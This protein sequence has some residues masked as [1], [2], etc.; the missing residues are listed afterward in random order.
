MRYSIFLIALSGVFLLACKKK[1]HE[2]EVPAPAF[3]QHGLLVL[4][5]GLFQLNNSTLCWVNTDDHSVNTTFFEDKTQRGLGDTG[6]D[7]ARYG[8]KIYIVVNVSSTIEVLDALTGDP[9]EQISMIHDNVA[10]QPRSIV[11]DGSKAFVSCYDGYV[12]VIDT[13]SLT[14]TQRIAVGSNPEGLDISNGKLYV[15]NSGGLNPVKDSTVSVISLSTLQEL[16]RITV[17]ENPGTVCTDSE[18]DVYVISRGNYDDI[19]SRM[20]RIDPATDTK[21]ESYAFDAS[22]I[23][24]MNNQL[25]ISYY[26]F[27]SQT[28]AIG[29][30][31]ALTEQL[32]SASYIST[33]SITTLYGVTYSPATNKIYCS[34]ANG[35]TNTGYIHLFS[36]SG[37]FEQSYHVGLNPSKLLVYE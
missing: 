25:L 31:N 8:N 33:A 26:D 27:D 22:G 23:T 10:K 15:A 17:G 13:A 24:R 34:D 19:P 9:I 14:V 37:S 4:N 2:P 28:S 30:F 1:K 3:L 12:D 21:V 32:I 35:Y 16:T 18:G 11:F 36:A 20:H 5:E 6:N 29:L 7:I